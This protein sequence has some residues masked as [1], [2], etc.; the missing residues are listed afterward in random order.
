MASISLQLCYYIVT[1]ELRDFQDFISQHDLILRYQLLYVDLY[2]TQ[3]QS[4]EH[5][6]GRTFSALNLNLYLVILYL[7]STFSNSVL[8]CNCYYKTP[9]KI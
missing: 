3:I 2:H 8:I 6:S 5:V 7:E 4:S 1:S 9:N